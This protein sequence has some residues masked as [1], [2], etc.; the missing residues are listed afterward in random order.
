MAEAAGS[1]GDGG[2]PARPAPCHY[3]AARD[4]FFR[5]IEERLYGAADNSM[6]R[7]NPAFPNPPISIPA[8]GD[9]DD[10]RTIER[11]RKR[12]D[13]IE[14]GRAKMTYYTLDEHMRHLDKI[15]SG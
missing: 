15:W 10:A 14:S 11:L 12:I 4:L 13:D 8:D 5:C 9:G 1:D 7:Q 3:D 6:R 2:S